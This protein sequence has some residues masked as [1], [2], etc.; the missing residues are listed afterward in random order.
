MENFLQLF[1]KFLLET[2]SI[3][4]LKHGSVPTGF[5]LD[6]LYVISIGLNYF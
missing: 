6:L 5:F 4:V 2:T 1:K 3:P